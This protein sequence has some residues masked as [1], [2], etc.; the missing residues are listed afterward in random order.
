MK[1]SEVMSLT[2]L[3]KKALNYY[4]DNGLI[5]PSVSQENNYRDYSDKDVELLTQIAT[6]RRFGLSVKEIKSALESPEALLLVMTEYTSKLAK[7]ISEM[8]KCETVLSSCVNNLKNDK[9]D[10]K[11]VTEEMNILSKAIEMSQKER[12]GFMISELERIFP[13]IYGRVISLCLSS[14]LTEPIDSKKKKKLG[15]ILL[16]F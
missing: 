5:S 7:Q 4:E 6:L 16:K 9:T 13:G 15:W 14:F 1:I 11:K 2:G 12:E 8:K 10:I 3:T